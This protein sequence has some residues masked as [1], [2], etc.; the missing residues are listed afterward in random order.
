MSKRAAHF[1]RAGKNTRKR[2]QK[3]SDGDSDEKKYE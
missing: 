3:K 1:V 2:P